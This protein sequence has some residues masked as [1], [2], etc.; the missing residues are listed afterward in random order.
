MR[1]L[2][3][4]FWWVR[5]PAAN[6][7]VMREFVFAWAEMFPEDE[8]ALVV[9]KKH[10]A[11]A[12]DLPPEC[13]LLTSRLW[14]QAAINVL[15][16]P[17]LAR[18]WGADVT[19]AHNFSPAAGRSV[20]FVHDIMFVE[21]PEWFSRA[22]KLYFSLM[23][24][25]TRFADVV[26]TSTMTE[27]GR[28]AR[29]CRVHRDVRAV[30]LGIAG[31]LTD[32]PPVRPE[33]LKVDRFALVV[34][35]LNV[36]KNLLTVAEAAA[37]SDQ[38]TP[39]CP[40]VIVGGGSHDGVTSQLPTGLHEAI[41][42][43]RIVMLGFTSD[44]ELRWLYENAV[45]CLSLSLDEGFGLPP[46]EAAHFGAPLLVSDIPVYRETVTGA[47]ARFVDPLAPAAVTA[48]LDEVL[49]H[50]PDRQEWSD[51]RWAWP[52]AVAGLREAAETACAGRE[53]T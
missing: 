31:A 4:G 30:G 41:S 14:P 24:R 43:G 13:T 16:L 35:R 38:V 25:T 18:R 22:E 10:A 50:V 15:E 53:R 17:L 39:E 20:T 6:R 23:P 32:H 19:L 3:D 33:Q 46:I 36:R 44:P 45:V 21:H 1:I 49:S 48:A 52:S 42:A 5:G 40:L 37:A 29:H 11:S 12:T 34:G 51:A 8:L 47:G 26:A 27:A 9:P 2:F 7:T 28:I